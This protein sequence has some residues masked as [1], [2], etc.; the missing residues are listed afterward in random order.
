VGSEWPDGWISA[1]LREA[2]IP[3]TYFART[4]LLKWQQS[5]P[6]LPYTNNPLG[7]PAIKGVTGELM[8]TG[9]AMFATMKLMRQQFVKFVKSP[10]GHNLHEALAVSE[11]AA[12]AYRAIH[13][14]KWPALTT[15]TDWPS[16]VLDMTT[17]SQQARLATVS[18]PADRKTSGAYGNQVA[19]GTQQGIS[20]RRTADNVN[21]LNRV[22]D[23]IRLNLGRII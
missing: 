15:E 11:S 14:L 10:A 3:V 8:Q 17:E 13:A 20:A 2:D 12:K 5:T 1:T 7:M 6:M 19:L 16:A 4:V 18:D 21:R 23:A 22:N 9:Y